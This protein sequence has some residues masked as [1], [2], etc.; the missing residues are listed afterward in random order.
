[1]RFR[2]RLGSVFGGFGAVGDAPKSPLTIK[3]DALA[4]TKVRP[5]KNRF[6][7]CKIGGGRKRCIFEEKGPQ[8]EVICE[9]RER[10]F[11]VAVFR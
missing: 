7:L 5:T 1:M 2:Y 8:K 3:N 6:F 4:V 10:L 11:A 9:V